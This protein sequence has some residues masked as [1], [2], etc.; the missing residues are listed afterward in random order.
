MLKKPRILI[1]IAFIIALGT[2]GLMFFH[3]QY[4]PCDQMSLGVIVDSDRGRLYLCENQKSFESFSVS[5]GRGGIEKRAEGDN[6]TPIGTYSLA[7]PRSSKSFYKFIPVGY[8]T[9][10]QVQSGFTGGAIGIHGPVRG[11]KIWSWPV[12]LVD[13]T[14]GCIAVATDEQITFIADWIEEKKV[15][16]GR[17]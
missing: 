5:L 6:R 10:A 8:P 15:S 17:F 2:A 7:S 11:N 14:R 4:D 16:I 1:W 3:Y 13:W 9:S 12:S